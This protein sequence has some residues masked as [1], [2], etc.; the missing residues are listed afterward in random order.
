MKKS[1]TLSIAG[2]IRSWLDAESVSF[3]AIC[4]EQITH[5]EVIKTVVG[6]SAF[7]MAIG[8]AGGVA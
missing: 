4:Q 5:G 8:M 3:T 2:A 1:G 7:F 6:L